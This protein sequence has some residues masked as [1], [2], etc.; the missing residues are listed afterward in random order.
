[1]G[2]RAAGAGLIVATALLALAPYS[3]SQG[4]SPPKLAVVIVVDQMR[5]DYVERF[6]ADWTGGLKRMVTDGAWFTNARYPYL[7]TV[8][9]AGHATVSTG[10]FP[11]VHGMFQNTWW[12]REQA[13][14]IS[15]TDDSDARAVGDPS[16]TKGGESAHR[17][18]VPTF[19]DQMRTERGSHVVA[20]S[21]K[22]D[23]TIMLAGHGAEV[24]VW[25]SSSQ[26]GWATSSAY[27]LAAPPAVRDFARANP[28]AADYGRTWDR[29]L[30]PSRYPEVDDGLAEAP[31]R[32]WQST[33]PH[34]LAGSS[35][36]PDSD[37]F[38]QWITS[39]FADAYVG[40]FAAALVERLGLGRRAT[41]DVLLAGFSSSDYVGHRFGPASQ[42]V[43][44]TYARLDRT[45]GTLLERLDTL[46][47]RDQYVV[48][49]T[50]DHG[51]TPIPEQLVAQG[52]AGGRLTFAAITDAIERQLVPA[53]G[54]GKH[55][56]LEN[57]N[58]VYF[59]PAVL[60]KLQASPTL[61]DAVVSA[62]AAVPGIQRVFRAE[63]ARL[64][65]KSDDPLLRAAALSYAPGR[66][67]DVIIVPESGWMFR[68]VGAGT[69]HATANA[70]D[71]RVPILLFGRGVKAGQHP[72]AAT[73]ADVAPTLAALCGIT[74]PSAE[75][76]TLLR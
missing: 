39:P 56:A 46:V 75:G 30:P 38:N 26:N 58:D 15:C 64:G 54:P 49:L 5:A 66:S 22:S 44:D 29:M 68:A 10:T 6:K 67:G 62:I 70:D 27:A 53:L 42:E 20:V 18:R 65:A 23:T 31:P 3:R 52:K 34:V 7:T 9:C 11:H 28:I 43:R 61:M 60:V 4:A 8:T 63:Q 50:A 35:A 32:G 69:T 13:K 21:L 33:F 37:F 14:R 16:Q 41:T 48:A 71:Q 72:E 57:G 36:V 74:M 2:N 19:S 76:H 40:R 45:L 17:L 47:G 12:D 59:E 24:A 25:L 51:V 73:P 1:M 55:V